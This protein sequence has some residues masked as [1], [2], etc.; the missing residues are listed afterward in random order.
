PELLQRSLQ[1]LYDLGG[2]HSRFR[3][4]SA[5][6]QAVV[7]QPEYVEARLVTGHDLVVAVLAPAA[8]GTCA[9]RGGGGTPSLLALATVIGVVASHEVLE[10]VV[11]EWV[12]LQRV[13]DVGAVV[14]E[15]HVLGPRRFA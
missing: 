15:P 8:F 13:L 3:Q 7:L 10:V 1:I 2:E 5:I 14:V 12:G 4:V 9:V 6:F 11:L